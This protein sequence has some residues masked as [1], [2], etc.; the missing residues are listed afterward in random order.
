MPTKIGQ[1]LTVKTIGEGGYAKVKLAKALD[2]RFVAIKVFKNT[3]LNKIEE[4]A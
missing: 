1:Y 2:G 4:E 3:A